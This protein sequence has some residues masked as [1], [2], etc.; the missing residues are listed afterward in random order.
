[1]KK[2]IL[3]FLVILVVVTFTGCDITGSLSDEEYEAVMKCLVEEKVIDAYTNEDVIG[4][5]EGEYITYT[6]DAKRNGE[7]LH[8]RMQQTKRG[9][10]YRVF[11]LYSVDAK[12][13]GWNTIVDIK[14][15]GKEVSL[16]TP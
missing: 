5:G 2:G 3:C 8:M 6:F 12:D 1:M 10:E 14:V 13:N 15:N 7:K 16:I 4:A 9:E 11:T